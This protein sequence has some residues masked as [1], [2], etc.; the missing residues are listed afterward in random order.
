MEYFTEFEVQSFEYD[1][2][3]DDMGENRVIDVEFV[4]K[5]ITHVMYKEEVEVIQDV[6]CPT[7]LLNMDIKENNI[8]VIQGH[9]YTESLVKGDIDVKNDEFKTN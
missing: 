7:K 2:R 4:V 3:Q 1:V 9:G 6:Y 8:N 5:A